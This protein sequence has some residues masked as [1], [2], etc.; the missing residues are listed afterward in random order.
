MCN[1]DKNQHSDNKEPLINQQRTNNPMKNAYKTQTG[2][3][4]KIVCHYNII[5]DQGKAN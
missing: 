5:N 4:K 3:S 2:I 1:K